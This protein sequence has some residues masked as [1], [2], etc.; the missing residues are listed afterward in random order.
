MMPMEKECLT[1]T[2]AVV[3]AEYYMVVFASLILVGGII[4]MVKAGSKASLI[5][6]TTIFLIIIG[7]VYVAAEINCVVGSIALFIL[8][9]I[10][11]PMFKGK[12]DKTALPPPSMQAPLASESKGKKKFM[13]FGLL[14][15]MSLAAIFLSACMVYYALQCQVQ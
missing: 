13:P 7:L 5:A 14:T 4:G 11:A 6:S 3:N 10:L 12:W 9:C 15:V 8:S 1:Y 2:G